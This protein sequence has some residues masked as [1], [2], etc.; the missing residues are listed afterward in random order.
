M[1]STGVI[2]RGDDPSFNTRM[3]HFVVIIFTLC[4]VSMIKFHKSDHYK[5][6]KFNLQDKQYKER[7]GYR[8]TETDTSET[9]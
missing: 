2:S 3:P 7:I 9:K 5:W 4:I 1:N 8:Q 6:V